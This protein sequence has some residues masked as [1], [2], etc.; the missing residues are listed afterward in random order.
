MS[1]EILEYIDKQECL[2]RGFVKEQD[3]VYHKR[4]M[5]E[6]YAHD[7]WLDKNGSST[8]RVSAGN[9]LG[10]DFYLARMQSI[11]ANDVGKIKVDGH[12][13]GVQSDSS[14]RALD[15]FNAAMRAVPTEFW[16]TVNTVCCFDE[17]IVPEGNNRS[18]RLNDK[19]EQ[20]QLLRLGL[21]RLIFHYKKINF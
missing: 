10:R 5:L 20:M 18:Q 8:D 12:G 17:D 16:P 1:Y 9:R 11:S 14:L 21:D 6:R 3:G 19:R 7:G 2:R 13:S 15:R 4:K